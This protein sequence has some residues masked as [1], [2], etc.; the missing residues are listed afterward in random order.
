MHPFWVDLHN[1]AIYILE[2][3]GNLFDRK[4]NFPILVLF[5]ETIKFCIMFFAD[6]KIMA[7]FLILFLTLGLI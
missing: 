7:R 5:S 6:M 2:N 1:P 3:C 4:Y